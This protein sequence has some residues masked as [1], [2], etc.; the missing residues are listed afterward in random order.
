MAIG[1]QEK[2]KESKDRPIG[3]TIGDAIVVESTR[4]ERVGEGDRK[5]ECWWRVAD[6]Y[7]TGY[8]RH[9]SSWYHIHA[10][11]FWINVQSV[12]IWKQR[13][14]FALRGDFSS[15]TRR[16]CMVALGNETGEKKGGRRGTAGIEL[17]FR[18]ICCDIKRFFFKGLGHSRTRNRKKGRVDYLRWLNY[19]LLQNIV[20][21]KCNIHMLNI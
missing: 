3:R 11:C 14:C 2:R 12:A 15:K 8:A 9:V 18:R 21:F 5:R 16:R 10:A 4:A 1:L 6:N 7:R 19:T 20:F 17:N 13:G